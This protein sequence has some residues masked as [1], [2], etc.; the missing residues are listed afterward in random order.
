MEHVSAIAKQPRSLLIP[1]VL[2][3]CFQGLMPPRSVLWGLAGCGAHDSAEGE[4]C[5]PSRTVAMNFIQ[6][7]TP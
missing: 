4:T 5:A 6:R 7:L 2:G 1:F 3:S